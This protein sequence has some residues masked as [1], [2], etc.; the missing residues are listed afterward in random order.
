MALYVV[1][2]DNLNRLCYYLTQQDYIYYPIHKDYHT[3]LWN[4]GC[5][6]MELLS[7]SRWNYL[8]PSNI[9]LTPLKGNSIRTFSESELS[10]DL[11]FSIQ[12]NVKPYWGL[13][14]R[15]L[16]SV[17]KKILP[18]P[19]VQTIDKS[20]IDYLFRYNYVKRL[21]DS[22][23]NDAAITTKMGWASALLA[24]LYYSQTLFTT[25]VMPPLPPIPGSMQ[26]LKVFYTD[27]PSLAGVDVD[28]FAYSIDASTMQ[29]DGDTIEIQAT[30][31]M[32]D[33]SEINYLQF[34]FGFA[35]YNFAFGSDGDIMEARILLTRV[36][37][38]TYRVS[39]L[40]ST[41]N[42]LPSYTWYQ[43]T[44]TSFA[45]GSTM[46]FIMNTNNNNDATGVHCIYKYFAAP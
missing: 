2:D 20:A 35:S 9:Q 45:V 7:P 19:Q 40:V 44:T 23:M 17:T 32:N 30:F 25:E 27:I 14:L 10:D 18:V 1:S 5:R 31:K 36:D 12:N 11:L 3:D 43:E 26:L 41:T 24:P 39:I 16:T 38:T 46:K 28:L 22:G 29:N 13:S 15:Q 6:P 21:R 33:I 37:S 8:S 4:T 34:D 42:G